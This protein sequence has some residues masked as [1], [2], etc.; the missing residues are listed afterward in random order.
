M[1]S[2]CA[3]KAAERPRTK[4]HRYPRPHVV[5]VHQC[6]EIDGQLYIDMRLIKGTDLQRTTVQVTPWRRVSYGLDRSAPQRP[7][8]VA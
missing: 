5:P 6:R 4:D 2:G 1:P 7:R 8:T 3:R